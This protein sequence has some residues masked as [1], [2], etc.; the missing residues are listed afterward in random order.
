MSIAVF[1]MCTIDG[2]SR[3]TVKAVNMDEHFPKND[4]LQMFLEIRFLDHT[5]TLQIWR[6]AVFVTCTIEGVLII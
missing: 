1:V 2:Y 4:E 3:D 5:A 6:S